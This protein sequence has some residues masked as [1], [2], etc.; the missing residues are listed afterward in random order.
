[1][2]RLAV[3]EPIFI[4][5]IIMNWP[6]ISEEYNDDLLLFLRKYI[7]LRQSAC[8]R[9]WL[10]LPNTVQ[11]AT[12]AEA[13]QSTLSPNL[14]SDAQ[15]GITTPPSGPLTSLLTVQKHVTPMSFQPPD[16]RKSPETS[17]E[18]LSHI[19]L[20]LEEILRA[21]EEKVNLAQASYDSVS[22]LALCRCAAVQSTF[23]VDRHIRLLDQAIKE[24]ETSIVLGI[25]SGTH[26]APIVLPDIVV[27]RWARSSRVTLS[28]VPSHLS[29]DTPNHPSQ[30]TG[31]GDMAPM[32]GIVSD[33]STGNQLRRKK[34]GGSR[35]WQKKDFEKQ[36]LDPPRRTTRSLK[37]TS[38]QPTPPD[39]DEPRYCYCNEV[40]FGEVSCPE[41]SFGPPV[42]Q[43]PIDDCM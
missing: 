26:P 5:V 36:V 21:S 3:R 18:M 10:D 15:D 31:D 14:T 27:P 1:M 40:S 42:Q 12:V 43:D 30:E 29:S 17:R 41:R 25:R 4:N 24:Q 9:H 32:I 11:S 34:G 28:P 37:R 16:R 7:I 8:A 39:Q 22:E 33:G 6:N 13:Y 23:K 35:K 19:A 2:S 20:L 38:S